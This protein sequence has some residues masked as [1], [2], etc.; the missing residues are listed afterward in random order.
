MWLL[1]MG[2]VTR[3][4]VTIVLPVLNEANAIGRVL[5]ELRRAGYSNILVVDGHS[6]DGTAEIAKS[7]GV[8]VVQ[9]HGRGKT[10]ALKTAFERVNTSYLLVMDGDC[11]YDPN[12]I[13]KFLA[14]AERYDYIIGAR[15][16]RERIPLLNRLGNRIICLAFNFFTGSNLSDVASGM[17]LLRTRIAR[18]LE[19][20][21]SGV[22]SEAEIAIQMAGICRVTEIPIEYRYRIGES[23]ASRIRDGFSDIMIIATLSRF[24]HPFLFFSGLGVLVTISGS[25][26]LLLSLYETVIGHGWHLGWII[27]G[28]ALI[29]F[30][31]QALILGTVSALLERMER[32]LLSEIRR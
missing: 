26:M 7:M 6:T 4:D 25:L 28:F 20:H 24:Y 16:R 29:F 19:L 31:A 18:T 3:N 30:G 23:K 8:E 17:Y 1:V 10:G 32:R 9:Q 5:D 2:I 21:S 22:D 13:E 27:I 11:T 15:T 12:D 14:H